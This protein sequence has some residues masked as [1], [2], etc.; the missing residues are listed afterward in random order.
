MK[1]ATGVNRLGLQ[2]ASILTTRPLLLI[3]IF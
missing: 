1:A 3:Y 2:A